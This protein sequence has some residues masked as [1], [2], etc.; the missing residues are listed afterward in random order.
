MLSLCPNVLF[1]CASVHADQEDLNYRNIYTSPH[2]LKFVSTGIMEAPPMYSSHFLNHLNTASDKSI[3]LHNSTKNYVRILFERLFLALN[4][5][6]SPDTEDV[7]M[8]KNDI[9]KILNNKSIFLT[10]ECTTD[11]VLEYMQQSGIDPHLFKALENY[12]RLVPIALFNDQHFQD[13]SYFNKVMKLEGDR[14]YAAY[15][16]ALQLREEGVLNDEEWN[17]LKYRFKEH[18][19]LSSCQIS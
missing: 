3:P 4:A 6:Q 8:A 15:E 10:G 5:D 12:V 13:C 2:R 16:V 18:M 7:R 11:N 1:I 19:R 17:D 9:H 14:S